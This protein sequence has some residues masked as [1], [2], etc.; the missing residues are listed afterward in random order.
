MFPGPKVHR[1][2]R[3]RLSRGQFPRATG[4]TVSA[5]ALVDTVTL[6]FSRPV[7]VTGLIPFLVVG[8]TVLSQTTISPTIVQIVFSGPLGG[9]AYSLISA[10]DNV[11]TYQG[12]PIA[13][14][15]GTFGSGP[16]LTT[17]IISAGNSGAGAYLVNFDQDVT[18]TPDPT[19]VDEMLFYSP[20][21]GTWTPATTV[22]QLLLPHNTI[23]ILHAQSD[24]TLIAIM[25][26]PANMTS[27]LPFAL[28]V[29]KSPIP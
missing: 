21:A 19:T 27:I 3:R 2:G 6:T 4:A 29:P 14:T 16:G 5:T 23:F 1:I 17:N 22:E 9:L 24:C 25:L 10:P 26:T 13:G 12:G 20:G 28:A 18:L 7:V 11:I 8:R 15:S